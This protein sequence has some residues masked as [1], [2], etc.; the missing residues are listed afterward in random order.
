MALT[1]PGICDFGWKARDFS[2]QGIDGKTY[3]LSDVRG[4]K[5]TLVAFICNHCPYVKAVAPRLASEIQALRALGIGAVAISSNDA[6][7]YPQD[8]FEHM[9]AFAREHGFEFPYLHDES[10]AVAKAY[11]AQCTPEFYGFDAERRLRYHGRLD[12]AGRNP[13]ISDTRRDLVEA[14][15]Q[16][17]QT[18]QAPGGQ[19][20][21]IGCSIKWKG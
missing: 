8:S 20:P 1:K 13:P 3:A 14:L 18:G 9:G 5:G 19:N 11:G 4:E 10:Q 21:S 2:L 17:A 7:A 15:T 6:E 12:A 16:L